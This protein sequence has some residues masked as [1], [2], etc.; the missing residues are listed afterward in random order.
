MIGY[1]AFLRAEHRLCGLFRSCPASVMAVVLDM[2][3]LLYLMR[4]EVG[5]QSVREGLYQISQGKL[6]YRI[7]T[8]AHD[9][10]EPG[11]GRGGER[12]GRR[13][14]S[15]RWI[16]MVQK[17]APESG[18]DHQRVPRHQDSADLYYQLC[19]SAAAGGAAE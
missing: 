5:K 12:D 14:C 3:V 2:A 19:G 4:D 6:D 13:D 9:R 8:E 16:A 11:D 7:E 18:A 10:G 15:K 17:R 1:V